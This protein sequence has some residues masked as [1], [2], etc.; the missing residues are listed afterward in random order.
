M[1]P[2]Q[3]SFLCRWNYLH[4]TNYNVQATLCKMKNVRMTV[5][6]YIAYQN[7]CGMKM[8]LYFCEIVQDFVRNWADDMQT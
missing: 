8:V 3:G 7:K 5:S 1:F 6:Y 2:C 4:F